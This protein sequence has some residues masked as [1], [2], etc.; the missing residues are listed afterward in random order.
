M[1]VC[2]KD[3]SGQLPGKSIVFAMTQPHAQRLR[4]VFEQMYPQYKD[5]VEVITSD[6]ERVRDGSYGDGLIT[7]SLRAAVLDISS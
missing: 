5:L 2:F 6:T 3:Q 1:E 4:L 7:K